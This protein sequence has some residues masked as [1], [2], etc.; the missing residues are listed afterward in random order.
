[1]CR[2]EAMMQVTEDERTMFSPSSMLRAN[3]TVR[4]LIQNVHRRREANVAR[5]IE[6]DERA[7]PPETLS[8]RAHR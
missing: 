7:R 8:S 6:H 1:M 3:K 4:P 5:R 2:V